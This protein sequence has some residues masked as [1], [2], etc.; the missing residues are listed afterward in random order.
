MAFKDDI[1]IRIEYLFSIYK[2]LERK[3]KYALH[4]LNISEVPEMVYNSNA[5]E[6]STLTLEETESIIFFDKIKK[7]HDIRE[8]YEAKNL[9]K[10][11]ELLQNNPHERFSAELILK[12]HRIL[13]NWINDHFAWR[14]RSGDEWVRVGSHVWANPAFVN[15]FIYDLV[16]KYNY[17]RRSYFLDKIAHFHAE[18]EIIHPFGDGN[19]R[20]GRVLINKQL[21]DLW[22]PPI[23]IPNK[24]KEKDYYP[25]FDKYLIKNDYKWFSKFFGLLLLESLNKRI[26]TLTAKRIIS[27]SEWAKNNNKNVNSY[28][29]KAKRQTIPSFRKNGKWMVA[30]EFEW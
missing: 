10:V 16:R 1:N 20:I 19:G 30:E 18:F 13:L 6:N 14:F 23:I 17:D 27:L 22:F 9:V 25:L 15:W 21:M 8:I 4:E 2:K 24:N 7:D 12:L 29:N 3:H 5:I 28:L 26:L 11:I